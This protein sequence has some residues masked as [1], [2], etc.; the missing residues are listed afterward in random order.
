MAT[1]RVGI[2]DDGYPT[3]GEKLLSTERIDELIRNEEDWGQ[4]ESLRDLSI[5]LSGKSRIWKRR[6]QFQAFNHPQTFKEQN[7][8]NSDFLI[9]DWEY[10]PVAASTDDFFEILNV[11]HS[12]IFIFSAY[13]TIDKIPQLLDEDRFHKFKMESRYVIMNKGE[14]DNINQIIKGI[15]EKFESG[16]DVTWEGIP[17]KIIPSR[18]LIDKDDFWKIKSVVG[19]E[20]LIEFAK[21]VNIFNE[22]NIEMLFNKITDNYFI[23]SKKN[24][25]SSAETELLKHGYGKMQKIS[26]IE[27]LKA[28]TIEKLEEA[29]E[30]GYTEIK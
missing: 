4:E 7:D 16:E 12:K 6:I 5:Q 10:K 18:H 22:E 27:A 21:Q 28:F 13:D 3:L 23:D 20:T 9:Y 15:M 24:I 14:D 2:I 1:V 19:T 25:L 29:K 11:T 30:K 8:F 26:A 17:I